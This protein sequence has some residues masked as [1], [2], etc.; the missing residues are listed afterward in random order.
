MC[1][2]FLLVMEVDVVRVFLCILV[3]HAGCA[4]IG[5]NHDAYF[6]T[7]KQKNVILQVLWS[8]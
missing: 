6:D 4:D 1:I 5:R 3:M 2:L 7:A 8:V